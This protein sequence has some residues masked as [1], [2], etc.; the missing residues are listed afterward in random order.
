M[1][2]TVPA[3]S[4]DDLFFGETVRRYVQAPRFIH[5]AW[6]AD[7]LLDVLSAPSCHIVVLTGAPGAGKSGFIAQLATDHPDW[8]LYMLRHDQRALLEDG[9]ARSF[10]LRIGFQLAALWPEL[11]SSEQVQIQIEQRIGSA[12]KDAS[13]V[14][15]EVDRI[16]TSPFH[17]AVIQVRQEVDL[18]A[19]TIVG[20]RV[21]EWAAERFDSDPP[22]PQVCEAHVRVNE[23][24]T[25]LHLASQLADWNSYVGA[26]AFRLIAHAA[27]G[28]QIAPDV[29]D[30]LERADSLARAGRNWRTPYEVA[31]VAVEFMRAG[32]PERAMHDTKDPVYGVVVRRALAAQLGEDGRALEALKLLPPPALGNSEPSAE[33]GVLRGLLDAGELSKAIEL[34]RLLPQASDR[35]AA[36]ASAAMRAPVQEGRRVATEASSLLSECHGQIRETEAVEVVAECLVSLGMADVLIAEIHRDWRSASDDTS[37]A[38]RILLAKPLV[39]PVKALAEKLVTSQA[40]VQTMLASI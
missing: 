33:L 40:Q 32:M 35:A 16:L 21:G 39:A 18:T 3:G 24:P 26:M 36:L 1:T 20:L 34:A 22:W 12:A 7:E 38:R 15:A 28:L 30:L 19:G 6:M 11:L 37:L 10:L 14:A 27:A 29:S 2:K 4:L 31:S 13:V 17:Q 8:L 5:R 23:L 25:A 9:S